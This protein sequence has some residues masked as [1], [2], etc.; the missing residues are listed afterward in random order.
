MTDS[1]YMSVFAVMWVSAAV[2]LILWFFWR[3]RK[4]QKR[5]D[6]QWQEREE[7]KREAQR[8]RQQH[9]K[10][11]HALILRSRQQRMELEMQAMKLV[12][13]M[14]FDEK[15]ITEDELD[16]LTDAICVEYE[17]LSMEMVHHEN[18]YLGLSDEADMAIMEIDDEETALADRE[19]IREW[20]WQQRMQ[21]TSISSANAS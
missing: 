9:L 21:Q 16:I 7:R 6:Q 14:H 1:P 8:Q 19:E 2:I 10:E 20:E 4:E 15:R 12:G 13:R 11:R 18:L 5:R 17:K 3:D